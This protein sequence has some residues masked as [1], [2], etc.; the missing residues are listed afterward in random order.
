MSTQFAYTAV[1]LDRSGG[2]LVRGVRE[3]ADERGLKDALREQGLIAVRVRPVRFVDAIRAGSGRRRMRSGDRLWFFETL[4]F[5]IG[6]KMP[7][8]TAM[9]EMAG[10]APRERLA[11][12]CREIRGRLRRGDAL[13][14]AIAE[15]SGGSGP[16][17][18]LAG[19]HHIAILRSGERSGQLGHAAGLVTRSLRNAQRM[20]SVVVGRLI[21]P[22][23]LIAAT[24]VVLWVLARFVVPRFAFTLET[25]G[26]ELPWQTVLTLWLSGLLLWLVPIGFVVGLVLVAAR[27]TIV[28]ARKRRA[29]SARVL[30]L[31]VVGSMVWHHQAGIVCDVLAS[32]LEGGGDVL[33]AMEQSSDVIRSREIRG[34]MDEARTRVREGAD[35]GAALRGEE[36][37]GVLPPMVG[38]VVGVGVR[39]GELASALRRAAE[40]CVERQE[41]VTQRLL[42]L[43]EPAIVLVLA[44]CVGWVVY[45]LVVGMLAM[46]DIASG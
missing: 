32:M 9:V 8:E 43:M 24:I 15:L 1:P 5:M 14:V 44:A 36:D 26:G 35:L 21:Y 19:E 12:V 13:S 16:G 11:E 4:A 28:P 38:A 42:T 33:E 39:T 3:A 30:R 2:A 37:D 31:P 45:S 23:I 34:R 10:A 17:A 46:T 29:W 25:L 18:G 22:V 41:R 7:I 27:D 6:S 20:R 40:M